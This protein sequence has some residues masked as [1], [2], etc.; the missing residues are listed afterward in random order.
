MEMKCKKKYLI[1][2]TIVLVI[3]IMT[4]LFVAVGTSA[5]ILNWAVND[6]DWIGFWGGYSGTLI[7]GI[8]TLFVLFKS[9]ADSKKTLKK[10]LE[11]ERYIQERNDITIF[12]QL[13]I[14]KSAVLSI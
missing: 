4:P 6:N 10:T 14:E 1:G 5:D 9:L 3:V 8:I 11:N 13:L 2:F 12:S 7:G